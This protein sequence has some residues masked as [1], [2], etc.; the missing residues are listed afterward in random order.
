MRLEKAA[1]SSDNGSSSGIDRAVN[2][3]AAP[4]QYGWTHYGTSGQTLARLHSLTH[5]VEIKDGDEWVRCASGTDT[6]FTPGSL[7]A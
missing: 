5:E 1:K 7:T 3:G 4:W 2:P 6:F